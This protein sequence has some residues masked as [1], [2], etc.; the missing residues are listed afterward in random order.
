M[1]GGLKDP[2]G[3]SGYQN[4][5]FEPIDTIPIN[6]IKEKKAVK[7]NSIEEK[8]DVKL[9]NLKEN[10]NLMRALVTIVAIC[11]LSSFQGKALSR[12]Q[13]LKMVPDILERTKVNAATYNSYTVYLLTGI[14]AAVTIACSLG[15]AG[16]F[17]TTVQ[18][19]LNAVPPL[20]GATIAQTTSW[21]S[22]MQTAGSAAGQVTGTAGQLTS[23]YLTGER[24]V[25]TSVIQLLTMQRDKLKE[26]DSADARKSAE[27][28]DMIIK[29]M[30]AYHRSCMQASGSN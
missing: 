16:A 23:Q 20:D 25:G 5:T 24:D 12:T 15:A 4:L 1:S 13:I 22:S 18:A 21:I 26:Y 14:G 19:G 3:G 7:R 8:I 11:A 29:V 6:E 28:L 30:E 27:F 10:D 17:Y 9:E 2:I